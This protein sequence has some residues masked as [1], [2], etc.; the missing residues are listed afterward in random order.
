MQL[1]NLI[2]LIQCITNKRYYK[3]CVLHSIFKMQNYVKGHIFRDTNLGYKT[4]KS[5]MGISETKFW[6][7]NT[8]ESRKNI[9]ISKG[10]P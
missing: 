6:V 3:I 7:I 9:I 8:S 1:H 5:S 4:V 2:F 10:V